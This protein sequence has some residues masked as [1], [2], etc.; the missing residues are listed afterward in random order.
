MCQFWLFFLLERGCH[1]LWVYPELSERAKVDI[2]CL[3]KE[4][5]QLQE[6]IKAYE[7]M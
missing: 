1:F 5:M 4:N 6:E 2:N 7:G 3:K